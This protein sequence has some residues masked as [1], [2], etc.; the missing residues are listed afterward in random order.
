[1]QRIAIWQHHLDNQQSTAGIHRSSTVTEDRQALLFA[2]IMDDVREKIGI[3]AAFRR[4]AALR[5][6]IYLIETR[7]MIQCELLS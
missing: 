1:M 7:P 3:A 4:D 6:T 2:P 5:F